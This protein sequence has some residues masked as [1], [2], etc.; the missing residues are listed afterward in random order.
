LPE[1]E[2]HAGDGAGVD[3]VGEEEGDD[4]LIIGAF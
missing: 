2:E 1:A 4:D 3:D